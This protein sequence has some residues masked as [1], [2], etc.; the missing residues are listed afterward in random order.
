MHTDTDRSVSAT[1][2]RM[3]ERRDRQAARQAARHAALTT[4]PSARAE[5]D[6]LHRFSSRAERLAQAGRYAELAKASYARAWLVIDAGDA[7][8]V[9]LAARMRSRLGCVPADVWT[10]ALAA[11]DRW[12]GA[13]EGLR[14][15]L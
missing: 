15:V 6:I 1:A 4:V 8:A 14:E 12:T 2:A 10:D 7:L 11:L 13:V 9:Q 3:T 5:A